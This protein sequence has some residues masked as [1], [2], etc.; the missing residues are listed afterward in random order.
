MLIDTQQRY[1]IAPALC[2]AGMGGAAIHSLEVDASNPT[3]LTVY[4]VAEE[5][6]EPSRLSAHA[7]KACASANSATR[8]ATYLQTKSTTTKETY[9]TFSVKPTLSTFVEMV[10]EEGVEPSRYSNT[11]RAR[12]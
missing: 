6:V 7:P 2:N 1:R 3:F 10:G 4:L 11:F 5:G 12:F 9:N 8:P